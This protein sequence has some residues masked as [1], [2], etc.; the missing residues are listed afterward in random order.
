MTLKVVISGVN[1]IEGGPL[2]VFKDCIRAFLAVKKIS[3]VCLVNSGDLFE[4]FSPAAVTFLE[5]PAVKKNWLNRIRFEY[6]SAKAL[7]RELQA[8]IWLSMHDISPRVVAKKQYVYCHNPSPFY[9]STLQDFLLDKKFFLFTYL[10]GY[11]YRLNIKSNSAVIVQQAWMAPF[12]KD[13]L[14]S[15]RVWVAQPTQQSL[16]INDT[17][18]VPQQI[19]TSCVSFFYPALPR[20]FK[21]FE[22][23]FRALKILSQDDPAYLN[24]VKVLVTISGNENNYARWLR[25][26][27]GDL[28]AIV[29][30]G[31]MSRDEVDAHYKNSDVV[32][33]PS[34]L[35]TWGLPISEAKA[36]GKPLLLADLPYAHETLGDYSAACFFDPLNARNLAEKIVKIINGEHLFDTVSYLPYTDVL[37]LNS[38]DKLVSKIVEE[39]EVG[40]RI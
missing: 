18:E 20:S 1:L 25:Q 26:E 35:E 22:V 6:F 7:S 32:V 13:L 8:D 38:W 2:E 29:W 39:S 40:L 9:K 33:F 21:N 17:I 15:P 27:F 24:R 36:L 3:L 10:Y 14:S 34:R 5:F 28:P 11:L 4:E 12:F 30:L 16:A 23:I 31:R 19:N 37:F